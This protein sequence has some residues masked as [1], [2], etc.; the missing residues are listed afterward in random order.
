MYHKLLQ[1][2]ENSCTLS[3]TR[4]TYLFGYTNQ[5]TEFNKSKKTLEKEVRMQISIKY[6]G[7]AIQKLLRKTEKNSADVS[8]SNREK[9]RKTRKIVTE[10]GYLSSE[11]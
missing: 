6:Y 11:S 9:L 4:K 5:I 3:T 7:R 2:E 1:L 8:K 10:K